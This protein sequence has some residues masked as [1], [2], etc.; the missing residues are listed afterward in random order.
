MNG[1]DVGAAEY[2]AGMARFFSPANLARYRK[3]ASDAIGDAERRHVLDVLAG[4]MKA[5]RREATRPPSVK[6]EARRAPSRRPDN[7]K[8]MIEEHGH[9]HR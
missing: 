5:F 9:E 4:E 2:K 1:Y 8:T 7:R 3:L 6:R